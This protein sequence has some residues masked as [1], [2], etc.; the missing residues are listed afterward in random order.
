V[1]LVTL[2]DAVTGFATGLAVAA[3]VGLAAL[4][5]LDVLARRK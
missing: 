3:I 2:W 1:T 5:I 4:G